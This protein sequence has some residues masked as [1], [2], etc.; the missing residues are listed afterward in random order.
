MDEFNGRVT[1]AGAACAGRIPWASKRLDWDAFRRA[2]GTWRDAS[3]VR[4]IAR[5]LMNAEPADDLDLVFYCQSGVRTTQLIFGLC[6]A[7]WPLEKLKNY[8]G[9][10]VEWSHLASS[11]E[12]RDAASG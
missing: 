3:E 6:R 9:S 12:I 1:L 5:E 10:W 11:E 7:G 2:D 4:Q 8:D